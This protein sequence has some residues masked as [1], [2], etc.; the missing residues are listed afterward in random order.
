MTLGN[1]TKVFA[2][3]ATTRSSSTS[4]RSSTSAGLRP[5]NNLHAIPLAAAPGVDGVAGYNTASIAIQ[6]PPT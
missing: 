1:G 6:V 4:A 2:G 3:R 5:F